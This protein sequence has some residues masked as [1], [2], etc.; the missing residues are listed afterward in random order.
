MVDDDMVSKIKSAATKASSFNRGQWQVIPAQNTSGWGVC[1]GDIVNGNGD[2][3][4]RTTG[5]DQFR[6]SAVAGHI[7]ACSPSAILELV[8]EIERLR[9]NSQAETPVAT[10]S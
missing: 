9:G 8:A 1:V 2:I 6:K 3:L 5:K 4:V 7:A 10:A